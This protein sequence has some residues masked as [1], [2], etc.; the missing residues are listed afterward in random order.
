MDDILFNDLLESLKEVKENVEGKIKLKTT[1]IN[2]S[3]HSNSIQE[4]IED[5][6]NWRIQGKA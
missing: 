2:T 1:K 6:D 3:E 4:K 5:E